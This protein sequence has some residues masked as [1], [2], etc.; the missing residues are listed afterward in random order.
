M[1]VC[2]QWL[3]R[4]TFRARNTVLA[5]LAA[6]SWLGAGLPAAAAAGC[7]AGVPGARAPADPQARGAAAVFAAAV[8]AETN[9][10]RRDAGLA[11]LAPDPRL[12]AVAA[13]HSGWMARAGRLS[14]VSAVPGLRRL[15]PRL[16]AAGYV[17]RAGAENILTTGHGTRPGCTHPVPSLAALAALAVDWWM[18][19]PPH[20]A[21]LLHG[22]VTHAGAGLAASGPCGPLYI[23]QE[24]AR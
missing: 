17:P 18:N 24:L 20:R 2:R 9:C 15:K 5:A 12:D 7:A 21:N 6:L 11:P 8:L 1:I 4:E 3:D 14:H 10:R 16:Q 23:T 19:S 22:G 13:G